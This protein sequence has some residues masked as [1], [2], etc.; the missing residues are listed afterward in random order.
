VGKAKKFSDLDLAI[1]VGTKLAHH[2]Y[3]DLKFAF[4]ESDLPYKVDIV[5]WQSISKSFRKTIQDDR[6]SLKFNGEV[7]M[8]TTSEK[9]TQD[10]SSSKDKDTVQETSEQSFPASDPPSWTPV[11]G[12][13][14]DDSHKK[15]D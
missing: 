2:T 3:V 5:D 4:E 9:T 15:K 1:D 6:I 11:T 8:S 14:E 13:K 12:E 7:T 10:N